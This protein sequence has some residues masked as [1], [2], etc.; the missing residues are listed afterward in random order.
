MNRNYLFDYSTFEK[1][2]NEIIQD[3]L[4]SV[5]IGKEFFE[6]LEKYSDEYSK[7]WIKNSKVPMT[8]LKEDLSFYML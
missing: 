6:N 1:D 4:A 8:R 2:K 3:F 5:K 7:W